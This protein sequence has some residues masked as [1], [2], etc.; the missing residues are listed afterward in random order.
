MYEIRQAKEEDREQVVELLTREFK[1]IDAF[2]EE[3]VDSWKNYWYK[4]EYDD[5]AFVATYGQQIVANLSYS[6]NCEFNRVRG[7]PIRF[8][9][10]W[11]VATAKAHRR[12][13]LLRR[14][15]DK[16]FFD[17]NERDVVLSILDPSPYQWAQTA[18][19]RMGYAL[20]EKRVKHR[21]APSNLKR[22]K[23]RDDIAVRR[24]ENPKE[25]HKISE[26]EIAM[27]RYGSRVLTYPFFF[28]QVINGGSFYLFERNDKPVGCVNLVLNK[29]DSETVLSIQFPYFSSLDVLPS[30]IQLVL[31]K[32]EDID[33]IEWICDP[34]IPLRNFAQNIKKFESQS[35]GSMMMRVVN[36]SNYCDSIEVSGIATV[37]MTIRL[38]DPQCS[39]NEGVY[40][41]TGDDDR[42]IVERDES[43]SN[44]DLTLDAHQLSMVV[45]GLTNP[46]DLQA[47]GLIN[48]HPKIA[49]MLDDVFP[50]DSFLSYFR[51]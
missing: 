26:L 47:Y 50:A 8:G 33:Y 3:W 4:P 1:A 24:L 40:R 9:G 21:F 49:L 36:F 41:L 45:G 15:Y 2:E 37:D 25:S 35:V 39:W 6:V 29:S 38:V 13:G 30:L 31:D 19:E 32:T 23:V 44:P 43:V 27:T 17:M 7:N 34:Q 18:Y 28:K 46:S 48:C 16:A 12:K 42:L 5:W 11:A 10:V 22:P 14:I 51:F 20:A